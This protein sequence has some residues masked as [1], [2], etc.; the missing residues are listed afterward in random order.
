MTV[1]CYS[2]IMR[3]AS[4]QAREKPP[5]LV[6]RFS[7]KSGRVSGAGET[8][9]A[10]GKNPQHGKENLAFQVNDDM[11][12]SSV[13]EIT[14]TKCIEDNKSNCNGVSSDVLD[15]T[16]DTDSCGVNMEK[17]KEAVSLSPSGILGMSR[18]N[19]A[20]GPSFPDTSITTEKGEESCKDCSSS[21]ACPSGTNGISLAGNS[22]FVVILSPNLNDSETTVQCVESREHFAGVGAGFSSKLGKSRVSPAVA[23]ENSQGKELSRSNTLPGYLARVRERMTERIGDRQHR[24]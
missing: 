6:G 8:V 16:K 17:S 20:V 3:V 10:D 7:A 5:T 4:H 12:E 11:I 14:V 22:A 2:R 24:R 1:V 9:M 21:N 23:E 15:Q 13:S 18:R 19:C